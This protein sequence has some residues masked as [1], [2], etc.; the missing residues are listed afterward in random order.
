MQQR[1]KRKHVYPI[2]INSLVITVLQTICS[3]G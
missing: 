3:D 2:Y 1:G